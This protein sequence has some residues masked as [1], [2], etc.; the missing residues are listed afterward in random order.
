MFDYK[1]WIVEY[2]DGKIGAGGRID[3]RPYLEGRL[4]ENKTIDEIIAW[5]VDFHEWFLRVGLDENIAVKGTIERL[6][7]HIVKI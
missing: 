2:M 1:Q 3:F 6:K 7:M 4:I 5:A